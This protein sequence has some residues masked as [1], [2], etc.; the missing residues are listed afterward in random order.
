MEQRAD[1]TEVTRGAE[2]SAPSERGT[3]GSASRRSDAA[4]PRDPPAVDDPA[5]AVAIDGE[6]CPVC[7]QTFADE[8]LLDVALDLDERSDADGRTYADVATVC[9]HCAD[10]LFDY[11]RSDVAVERQGLSERETPS[12][13]A[14][15]P[16]VLAASL[17][18]ALSFVA[19]VGG[20][21]AGTAWLLPALLL[22]FFGSW[23]LLPLA[24]FY[25]VRHQRQ[26]G[27]WSAAAVG[28]IPPMAVPLVN[29]ATALAYALRR[30]ESS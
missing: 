5:S 26:R 24:T 29:V 8:R 15:W 6:Q 22:V 12:T 18:H 27:T 19:L 9:E 20:A 14:W 11:D 10:S 16:L 21:W 28:W 13:R 4:R 2:S 3:D 25:D 1:T 23:A 17:A 7:R 30:R